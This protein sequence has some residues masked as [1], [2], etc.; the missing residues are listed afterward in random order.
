MHTVTLDSVLDEVML[1]EPEQRER[2]VEIIR[3]RQIEV[4][5]EQL[6]RD[7]KE[8]IAE[9]ERGELHPMTA[10]EIIKELH[11]SLDSE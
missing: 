3:A 4:E 10:E 11:E 7:V 6:I 8:G 1:L 5:R 2:L 9:F